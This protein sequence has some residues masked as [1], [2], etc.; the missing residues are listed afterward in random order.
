MEVGDR[1]RWVP[2]KGCDWAGDG[3]ATIRG[4][5]PNRVLFGDQGNERRGPAVLLVL[6]H[7]GLDVW[8]SPDELM[9]YLPE[10]AA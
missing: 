9:A 10:V 4:F 7:R 5:D 3:V 8:V 6:D 1:V 2:S